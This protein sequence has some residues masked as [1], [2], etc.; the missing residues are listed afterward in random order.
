MKGIKT[1]SNQ[2]FMQDVAAA[3]EEANRAP[4]VITEQG[5]PAFV[6]LSNREYQKLSRPVQSLVDRLSVEDDLDID[7]EPL[8]FENQ[9]PW[10]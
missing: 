4:V 10:P 6:L 3:M 1:L 8:H 2:A 5:E 9:N 7:F